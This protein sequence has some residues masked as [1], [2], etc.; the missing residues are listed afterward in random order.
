MAAT[1]ASPSTDEPVKR[2][3]TKA[4]PRPGKTVRSEVHPRL[5]RYHADR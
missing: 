1:K 2:T 5:R 3:A 4:P